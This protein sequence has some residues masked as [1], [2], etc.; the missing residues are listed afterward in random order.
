MGNFIAFA[1]RQVW[2]IVVIVFGAVTWS[3]ATASGAYE[4]FTLGLQPWALQLIGGLTVFAGMMAALYRMDAIA[5][6]PAATP[7]PQPAALKP[8]PGWTGGPV[9]P[10]RSLQLAVEDIRQSYW[11]REHQADTAAAT[12]DL[13]DKLSLGRLT[14]W[15]AREPEGRVGEIP[16]NGWLAY[17]LDPATNTVT[18]NGE[19][20][21]HRAQLATSQVQRIWPG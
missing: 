20:V 6:A 10:N 15:G 17:S 7:E 14:V 1:K 2:P 9:T 4:F 16:Q 5:S 12:Q 13:L 19:P 18:M 21:Y 3:Y 11:G 8:I